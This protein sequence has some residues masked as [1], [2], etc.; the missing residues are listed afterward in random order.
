MHLTAQLTATPATRGMQ[1][2]V[3]TTKHALRT[4]LSTVPTTRAPTVLQLV[5]TPSSS[6]SLLR[7]RILP[8]LARA[9]T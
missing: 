5:E 8:T 7:D 2:L 4:A 1:Q 6:S 3:P 9:H